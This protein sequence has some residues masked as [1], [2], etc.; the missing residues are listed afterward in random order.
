MAA[1]D[2]TESVDQTSDIHVHFVRIGLTHIY[3]TWQQLQNEGFVS[4]EE[5]MPEGT[6]AEWRL[7]DCATLLVRRKWV[8]GSRKKGKV[9]V[10]LRDA[11]WWCITISH[12]HFSWEDEEVRRRLDEMRKEIHSRTV[13]GQAERHRLINRAARAYSDKA[14]QRFKHS[15][16]AQRKGGRQHD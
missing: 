3:G 6:S 1:T 13:E 5:P 14:F 4:G 7:N 11:D 2:D 9:G 15:L 8:P 12:D 16:L 10:K